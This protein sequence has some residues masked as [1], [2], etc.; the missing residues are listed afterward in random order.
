[1]TIYQI[2]IPLQVLFRGSRMRRFAK[3]FGVGNEMR[4]IDVGGRKCNWTLIDKRP[5]VTITNIEFDSYEDGRF[6]YVRTNGERLPYDDN[7]FAVCYS[8]SVIEHVGDANARKKFAAEIRRVAPRYYVQTPYKWFFFDPHTVGAFVHWL[9]KRWQ[10]RLIRWCTPWGLIDRP[11]QDKVDALIAE[12]DLLT[13][14]EMRA[15][16]P[17]AQIIKERFF[18]FTKS[19]IAVRV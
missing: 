11:S 12:I 8:N 1:M 13:E 18:G 6:H 17:D 9:P 15:L 2:I 19:L 3:M 4:I 5:D 16:F 14:A 10:R 7:S